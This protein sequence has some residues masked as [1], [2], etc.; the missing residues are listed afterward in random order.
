MSW[1]IDLD[2]LDNLN[3]ATRFYVPK[4]EKEEWVELRLVADDDV[5]G[6]R[7]ECVKKEVLQVLNKKT[8]R[9][10]IVR[11]EDIDGEKLT[12]MINDHCIAR[13]L[14]YDKNGKEVPC[15]REMKNILMGKMPPFAA[16]IDECLEKLR[17]FDQK[18]KESERKNL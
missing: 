3:P 10:E 17:E 13:W 9:M 6:F 16:W 2:N 11:D 14:L 18:E 7:K 1:E 4:S 15:T 8:R 12:E 5:K